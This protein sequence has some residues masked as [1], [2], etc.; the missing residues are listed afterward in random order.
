MKR[1]ALIGLF[2]HEN[3]AMELEL[4][5]EVRHQVG[6]ICLSVCLF[7]CLPVSV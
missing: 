5:N 6:L 3:P 2:G 1:R 4:T 7:V